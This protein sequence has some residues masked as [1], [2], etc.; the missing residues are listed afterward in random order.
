MSIFDH[1][2]TPQGLQLDEAIQSYFY[3]S[4]RW[5]KFLAIMG[6]IGTGLIVLLGL[7]MMLGGLSTGNLGLSIAGP[8]M[9]LVYF[10]IAAIYFVPSY[11]LYKFSRKAMYA[12]KQT[13]QDE[14][15]LSF[16][17]LNSY[18]QFIGILMIIVISLYALII[19][20]AIIM[21]VIGAS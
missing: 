13:D 5:G 1:N 15:V 7:F 18:F 8:A 12:L 19:I 17:N 3:N 6:F 21:G 2:E 20:F 10:L 9:S 4:A 14:L 11:F 16:K